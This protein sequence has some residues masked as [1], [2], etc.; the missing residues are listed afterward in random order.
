MSRDA[1]P[2]DW[3]GLMHRSNIGVNTIVCGEGL[4]PQKKLREQ[5]PEGGVQVWMGR[6]I[7]PGWQGPQMPGFVSVL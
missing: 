7:R 5:M 1:V 3:L 4:T 2:S 6:L